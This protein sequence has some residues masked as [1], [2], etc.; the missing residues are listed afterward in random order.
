MCACEAGGGGG[1]LRRE[2]CAGTAQNESKRRMEE[3]ES[4]CRALLC[5]TVVT[6]QAVLPVCRVLYAASRVACR[7]VRVPAAARAMHG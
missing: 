2:E 1:G 4:T 6:G 3:L 5:T 7:V